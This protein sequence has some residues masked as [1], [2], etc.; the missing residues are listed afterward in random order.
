M[1]LLKRKRNY[2]SAKFIKSKAQPKLKINKLNS[3]DSIKLYAY[4]QHTTRNIL[5]CLFIRFFL[6]LLSISH[7]IH[8]SPRSITKAL[9]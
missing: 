9:E 7:Q 5:L 4:M 2:S 1:F 6:P 3:N 8:I